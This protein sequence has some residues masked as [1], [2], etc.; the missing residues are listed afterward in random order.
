[1]P[2]PGKPLEE[3]LE[4]LFVKIPFKV[5][6]KLEEIV[7]DDKREIEKFVEKLVLEYVEK[8]SKLD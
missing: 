2:R 1:M 6:W 5:Y 7:S 4:T 3:R 8:H